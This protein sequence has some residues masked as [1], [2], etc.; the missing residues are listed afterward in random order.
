AERV[1]V[2]GERA[3]RLEPKLYR[4][5]VTVGAST[6]GLKVMR[7]DVE[8]RSETF[9][10]GLPVDPGTY[11]ITATA[12]NKKPWTIQ[13]QIPPGPG[14]QTV[15]VPALED[16]PAALAAAEAAKT[17]A[18]PPIAGPPSPPPEAPEVP[19]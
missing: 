6:P 16:D 13:V 18:I 7:G 8:V 5:T 15:T 17:A 2:A 9:G 19:G 14:A 10:A 12:K 3:A 1:R 4:L 11:V